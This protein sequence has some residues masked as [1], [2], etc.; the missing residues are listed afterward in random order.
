MGIV[1]VFSTKEHL[2]AD[3]LPVDYAVNLILAATWD[4]AHNS[5]SFKIFNG[6]SQPDAPITWGLLSKNKKKLKNY[7]N[8]SI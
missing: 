1:H 5:R 4:T 7:T 2:I 6:V 8:N 3:L